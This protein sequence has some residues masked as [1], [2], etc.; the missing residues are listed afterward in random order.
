MIHPPTKFHTNPLSHFFNLHTSASGN[1][2]NSPP[3]NNDSKDTTIEPEI[4]LENSTN[5][6]FAPELT[7]VAAKSSFTIAAI[8]GLKKNGINQHHKFHENENHP[9]VNGRGFNN[10]MNLS[11]SNQ[12]PPPNQAIIENPAHQNQQFRALSLPLH[13][14]H[15]HHQQQHLHHSASA[16][17]SALQSLQ[18]LQQQHTNNQIVRELQNRDKM[19]QHGMWIIMFRDEYLCKRNRVGTTCF[20]DVLVRN[21]RNAV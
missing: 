3:V 18:Q 14:H 6:N 17:N 4:D 8:L 7:S 20:D 16:G 11:M 21:S 5:S 2:N 12:R 19:R 9:F 15:Y 10:V 13:H 1:N